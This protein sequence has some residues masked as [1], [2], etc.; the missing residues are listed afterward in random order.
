MKNYAVLDK[1]SKVANIIVAP[2]LE[3]AEYATSSFC[4][5]IP[6]GTTVDMGYSY[7]NGEFTGPVV[8]MTPP[9]EPSA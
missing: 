8:E 7:S 4:V 9:E 1:D 6:L 3:A 2:S 5:V